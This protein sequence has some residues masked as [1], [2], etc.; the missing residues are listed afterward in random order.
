MP[1]VTA[2]SDHT[3]FGGG[4]GIMDPKA[5]ED[6]AFHPNRESHIPITEFYATNPADPDS[7]PTKVPLSRERNSWVGE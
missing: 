3:E 5:R 1:Y 2:P 4:G 6:R 7:D